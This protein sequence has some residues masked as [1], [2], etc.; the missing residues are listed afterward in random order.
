MFDGIAKP[1][2]EPPA[3][4]A[5][6]M[7]TTSPCMFTSGPPELPGLM[8]VLIAY[9]DSDQ[10]YR[11]NNAA[12]VEWF[13]ISPGDAQGRTIREVVGEPF[14][15][16]VLPH[17]ERVLA[18]EH[19]HYAQDTIL[20]SGNRVSVEAIYVPD[21]DDGSVVRGFYA[22]VM[23]VTE[24]NAAQLESRR[25]QDELLHASRITTTGELAGTLAHEI[26]QPL[27]AIM[28]NAQAATRFLDFP[29]PDLE[30]VKEILQ[31]IVADDARAGQVINRLRALLKK[32]KTDFEDPRAERGHSGGGRVCSQRLGGSR[33]AGCTR[34]GFAAPAGAGGQGPIAAGRL[35]P[36]AERV[37]CRE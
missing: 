8:A 18:G 28:S 10:R 24:R 33:R 29:T 19:V 27:S 5:V 26:N 35:E 11:F 17:V 12:Y 3:T 6:L 31:D 2:P 21:I 9:V 22:L 25:L 4:I 23:N 7:P 16:G 34:S 20:P 32:A 14:Y 37:R 36:V 13:G 30:E 1:M 15:R